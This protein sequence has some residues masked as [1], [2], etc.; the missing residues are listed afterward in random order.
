MSFSKTSRIC[1]T[2]YCT[3]PENDHERERIAKAGRTMFLRDYDPV[4]HGQQIRKAV[5]ELC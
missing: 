3:T 2:S 4:K 5:E 1:E